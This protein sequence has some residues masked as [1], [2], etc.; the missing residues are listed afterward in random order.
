MPMRNER[1]RER[2]REEGDE[3]ARE[4]TLRDKRDERKGFTSTMRNDNNDRC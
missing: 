4:T 2:E 3:G 1:E